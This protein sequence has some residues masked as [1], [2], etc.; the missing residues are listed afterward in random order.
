MGWPV[1]GYGLPISWIWAIYQLVMGWLWDIYRLAM[2][3]LGSGVWA[4]Y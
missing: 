2:G 1:D 3:W 4:V